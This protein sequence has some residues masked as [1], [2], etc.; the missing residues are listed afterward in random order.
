MRT[1]PNDVDFLTLQRERHVAD[2]AAGVADLPAVDRLRRLAKDL[3]KLLDDVA[4]SGRSLESIASEVLAISAAGANL[5]RLDLSV[6]VPGTPAIQ[7]AFGLLGFLSRRLGD[8]AEAGDKSPDFHMDAVDTVVL[9]A[10]WGSS[11]GA[12]SPR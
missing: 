7:P 11:H 8:L 3:G 12:A 9:L 10:R 6:I 4:R 1:L 5:L 2:V